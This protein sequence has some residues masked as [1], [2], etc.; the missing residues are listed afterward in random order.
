MDLII[1]GFVHH[2]HIMGLLLDGLR[3]ILGEVYDTIFFEESMDPHH[4]IDVAHQMPSA[5]SGRKVV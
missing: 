4:G 1:I 5:G 2:E 3:T